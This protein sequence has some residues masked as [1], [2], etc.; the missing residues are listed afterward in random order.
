MLLALRAWGE[1]WCKTPREGL[2]VR[3]THQPCG[4]SAGLGPICESCDQPLRRE[5]L[6][7]EAGPAY[8]DEREARW[9]AFKASR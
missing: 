9:T 5:D 8:R 4:K 7:R 1:A 3:Y 6:I 2:A